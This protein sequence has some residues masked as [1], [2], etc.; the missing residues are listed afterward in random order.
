MIGAAV[1]AAIGILAAVY[2]VRA[3]RRRRRLRSGATVEA[4][5]R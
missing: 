4:Q 3:A 5:L 1:V 2:T